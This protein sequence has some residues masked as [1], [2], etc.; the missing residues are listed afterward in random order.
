MQ[1][2]QSYHVI[3]IFFYHQSIK[4]WRIND[5]LRSMYDLEKVDCTL[6]DDNIQNVSQEGLQ[7]MELMR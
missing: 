4:R 7:F 3:L 1:K 5:T 2:N 6:K